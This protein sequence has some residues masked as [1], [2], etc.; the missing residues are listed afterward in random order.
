MRAKLFAHLRRQ[1]M[2]ALALFLVLTGGTAWAVDEWTGANIQDG[3]LGSADYRNN[4]IRRIDIRNDTA[5]GGGLAAADLAPGSA[6]L[7][8]LDPAAFAAP[9]IAPTAA[10]GAFEIADNA[11]QGSEITDGVIRSA[12]VTDNSLAANDIGTDAVGSSEIADG[13]VRSEELGPI[14]ERMG[15]QV[16]PDGGTGQ[17][18]DWG[19]GRSTA[20]CFAGDELLSAY[21][22][23]H[24]AEPGEELAISSLNMDI[25][26]E[27]AVAVGAS[28]SSFDHGFEVFAVC[29]G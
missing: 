2:G 25:D 24:G 13:G 5:V 19:T 7:G 1:W 14:Y 28:D 16:F 4:D 23:W 17:N 27:T 11:V 15:N 8:E 18:G 12:D 29:L 6:G 22:V 9:D 20:S 21:A 10:G 3:T 26:T